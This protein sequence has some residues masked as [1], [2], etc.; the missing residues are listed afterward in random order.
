VSRR[1]STPSVSSVGTVVKASTLSLCWSA[2]LLPLRILRIVG[3]ER[4]VFRRGSS[5]G[6]PPP[7]RKGEACFL[8][9][10]LR[11]KT[12]VHFPDIFRRSKLRF[13]TSPAMTCSEAI[14][15]R[16]EYDLALRQWGKSRFSSQIWL[17]CE[18]GVKSGSDKASCL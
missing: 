12:P 18:V 11:Q 2:A 6:R 15:L 10:R 4:N 14:R 7:W 13:R 16:Q 1:A 5:I 8:L 17:G 3:V 9:V